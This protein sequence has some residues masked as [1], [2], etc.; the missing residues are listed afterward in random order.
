MQLTG[1]QLYFDW[2]KASFSIHNLI[3]QTLKWL[4]YLLLYSGRQWCRTA[5]TKWDSFKKHFITVRIERKSIHYI[6]T[7]HEKKTW[8]F[9]GILTI[10]RWFLK[11]SH[12]ALA[13]PHY[14]CPLSITFTM[15]YYIRQETF[16]KSL[17]SLSYIRRTSGMFIASAMW[18]HWHILSKI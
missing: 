7:D 10:L 17:S 4:P 6:T 11:L 8:E 1:S 5:T 3:K 12:S 9:C 16:C 14:C 18:A 13:V 2:R 15:I